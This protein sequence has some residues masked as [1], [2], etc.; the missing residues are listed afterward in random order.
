MPKTW[1]NKGIP[2]LHLSSK[3]EGKFGTHGDFVRIEEFLELVKLLESVG[4]KKVHIMIE[5]KKK[6]IAIKKLKQSINQ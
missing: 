6:E 2:K 4:I 1:K 3:G 5:A